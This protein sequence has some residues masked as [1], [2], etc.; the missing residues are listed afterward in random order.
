[1]IMWKMKIMEKP[2]KKAYIRKIHEGHGL[3]IGIP[4]K[5]VADFD[6][7]PEDYLHLYYDDINGHIVIRKVP[8][9][10]K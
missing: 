2:N 7:E 6:L 10:N 3:S 5:I 8:E 9:V 1:M 4:K